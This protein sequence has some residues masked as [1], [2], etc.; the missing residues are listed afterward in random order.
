MKT[1]FHASRAVRGGAI[2]LSL[3]ASAVPAI[4]QAHSN[5]ASL[6]AYVQRNLVSDDGSV[7][8][9]VTDP[10]LINPWGIA[11]SPFGP[12][13][14]ADNGAG[15]STLYDGNGARQPLV[16][17]I[18][19]APGEMAPSNPTGVVF[20]GS[21]SFVVTVG[22]TKGAAR[23]IFATESGTLAAWSPMVDMTHAILVMDNSASDAIYKGLALAGNGTGLQLYATDF[24]NGRIDVF[25]STFKPVKLPEGA[26]TDPAI[27]AGYGPFGI[28]NI[29]GNLYV[30]YAKQDADKED[31]VPG[32]GFG[33]V[34]VYDANGTLLRR[35]ISRGR[36]NAPWGLALAPEGFGKFS[37]RLLVGNF[38]DGTINAFDIDSGDS[39]G[40]LQDAM[41][42]TVRIEGL[43]GLSFGNG[44]LM[45]PTNTLFFTSGPGDEEHGLFGRLDGPTN[46]RR[47]P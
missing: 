47:G 8:G 25:D 10:N 46:C 16:V 2:A 39:K 29:L 7:P 28:Q 15:V 37:N 34:D 19:P 40:P 14:V 11:F 30:T 12:V 13:W 1:V 17:T 36:L 18:P 31:D 4:G 45:Q 23:F 44:V 22:T 41:G 43:W 27:P 21:E 35:L 24:H 38:G 20:N 42:N 9:T 3:V 6:N 32:K 5:C 26:F 33:F